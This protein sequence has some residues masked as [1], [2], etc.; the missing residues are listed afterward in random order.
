MGQHTG[1]PFP[2]FHLILIHLLADGLTQLVQRFLHGTFARQQAVSRHPKCEVPIADS[3]L[4]QMGPLSQRA[5][6]AHEPHR[7]AYKDYTYYNYYPHIL[8]SSPRIT[9]ISLIGCA[10]NN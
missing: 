10:K 9:R 6:M 3:L 5:L 2:R 1:E 7:K 4:H 8:F